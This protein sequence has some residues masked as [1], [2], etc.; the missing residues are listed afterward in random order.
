MSP[1]SAAPVLCALALAAL[2][3]QEPPP[4]GGATVS[5]P[6]APATPTRGPVLKLGPRP[7]PKEIGIGGSSLADIARRNRAASEKEAKKKSLGVISNESLRKGSAP[8]A[9]PPP[10]KGTEKP[11]GHRV[12]GPSTPTP[13]IPE[14][15]DLEGRTESDWR[16]I[17]GDLRARMVAAETSV[18]KLDAEVRRLEN[19]FYA[20]SDGNYRDRVIKPALDQSRA[21][22]DKAKRDAEDA[23]AKLDSLEDDARKSGAPPGW[24]R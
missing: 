7:T 19:D 20:W 3:A 15:K 5:S 18:K 22:L 24:L 9:T 23:K 16:R 6:E 4:E 14:P 12:V 10:P 17:S 8:A 2:F 21:D 13:G 11:V 1:A